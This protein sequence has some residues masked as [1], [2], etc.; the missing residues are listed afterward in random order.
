MINLECPCSRRRLSKTQQHSVCVLSCRTC[1]AQSSWF[2]PSLAQIFLAYYWRLG[3]IPILVSRD[4]ASQVQWCFD[5]KIALVVQC[6]ARFGCVC[7][8]VES[9][10]AYG[11]PINCVILMCRA[12]DGHFVRVFN[13]Y[14]LYVWCFCG[15]LACSLAK[16]KTLFGFA[17]RDSFCNAQRFT[18][19]K[20]LNVTAIKNVST[21]MNDDKFGN[22]NIFGYMDLVII[23]FFTKI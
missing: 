22:N 1:S 12:R 8:C 10:A 17:A 14:V 2:H 18:L 23:G 9:R 15:R 4:R 6:P 21:F 3:P 19:G 7:V 11:T 13:T 20:T 16:P 5:R